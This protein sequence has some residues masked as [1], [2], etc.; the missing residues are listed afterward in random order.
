MAK[1]P[2]P[3]SVKTRLCPPLTPRR[4]ARLQRAFLLDTFHRLRAVLR[5]TVV[6]AFWPP[7]ARA[8]FARACPGAVLV[9]QRGR[10]LGA[11]MIAVLHRLLRRGFTAVVL[12]G[13]DVPTVPTAYL[14]RATALVL[15][16]RTDVVLGPA[17]DGGYYL[18]GMRTL[19]RGIF[20][21]IPWST[22]GVFAATM[23]RA[24]R[25]RLRVAR[26]PRWADVDTVDDLRRLRRSLAQGERLLAPR[27]ARALL[28][29]KPAQ[30]TGSR[31]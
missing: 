19:H 28:G 7:S 16:P 6:V 27:T 5:A 14:R 4:A 29:A 11:R 25:D 8:Y 20:E 2:R 22:A 1:A 15:D 31:P 9:P 10:D 12:L 30:G 3:G 17:R 26:L 23:E 21:R 13:S 24:A 18:V